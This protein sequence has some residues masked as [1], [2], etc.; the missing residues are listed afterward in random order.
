MEWFLTQ[1]K[2][3]PISHMQATRVLALCTVKTLYAT[4]RWLVKPLPS[5]IGRYL[6]LCLS[7][8]TSEMF[9]SSALF[10]SHVSV[11]QQKQQ[12][13]LCPIF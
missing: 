9:E 10:R 12:K 1:T 3:Q 13:L 2:I 5:P 4:L 11:D 8:S 6:Y 7:F